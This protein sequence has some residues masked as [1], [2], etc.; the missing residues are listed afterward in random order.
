MER[1]IPDHAPPEDQQVMAAG[2]KWL[3][4]CYHSAFE[5]IAFLNQA[6]STA[7]VS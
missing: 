6:D 4:T 2:V 5:Q 1:D 3:A 7:R